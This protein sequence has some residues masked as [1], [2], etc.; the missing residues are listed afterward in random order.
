MKE[1]TE[2]EQ[3]LMLQDN[4]DDKGWHHIQQLRAVGAVR[5]AEHPEA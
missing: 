5:L 3:L 2:L 4:V 1:A